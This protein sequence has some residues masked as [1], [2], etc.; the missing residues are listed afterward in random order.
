V[1]VDQVDVYGILTFKA[2]DHAKRKITRQLALTLTAQKPF[3][4][5]LS[6]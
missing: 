3:S 4:F 5:P 1:V 6:G 2:K